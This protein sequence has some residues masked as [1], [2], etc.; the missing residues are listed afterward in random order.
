MLAV[1][2]GLGGTLPAK[3]ALSHLV[4]FILSRR[5]CTSVSTGGDSLFWGNRLNLGVSC[6][7]SWPVRASAVAS[8]NRC[9][10]DCAG[11]RGTIV[12]VLLFL[13]FAPFR[14]GK[15][16]IKGAGTGALFFGSGGNGDVGGGLTG[17]TGEA[18]TLAD[19]GDAGTLLGDTT[20]LRL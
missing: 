4:L 11:P 8:C 5:F 12:E 13:L 9:V 19:L 6:C 10:A 17:E 7:R 16:R 18:A 1:V 2:L 15:N 14:F 3:A 20:S